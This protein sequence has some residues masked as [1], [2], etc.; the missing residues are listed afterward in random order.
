MDASAA[1]H[2]EERPFFG[3]PFVWLCFALLLLVV[4]IVGYMLNANMVWEEVHP[5]L[6]AMFNGTSA[7]FLVAGYVA[8]RRGRKAFHRSCMLGAFTASSVFLASYLTRYA[9]SGTHRYPGDG[10]DKIAYLVILM[11]HMFLAMAVVPLVLRSLWL[12][13][14]GRFDAHK[15]IVRFTWP[16]WMYVSVTGV[17]IYVML[18]PIA[19]ALYR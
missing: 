16:I 1:T 7:V 9:I 12:A 6:N 17:A 10:A 4:P 3:R 2:V 13:Y 18:Y 5:A 14:K 15:R 11:S 19:N 8:I